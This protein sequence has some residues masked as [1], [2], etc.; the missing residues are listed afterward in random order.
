M[1]GATKPKGSQRELTMDSMPRLVV[2][3]GI[4]SML[5]VNVSFSTFH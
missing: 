1:T 5:K 2:E 4:I 3:W